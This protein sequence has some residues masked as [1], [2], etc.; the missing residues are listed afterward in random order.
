MAFLA[1]AIP[2][3]ASIAG[4]IIGGNAQKAAAST[5]ANSQL[6]LQNQ[7]YQQLLDAEKNYRTQINAIA[8]YLGAQSQAATDIRQHVPYLA[9]SSATASGGVF[10]GQQVQSTPQPGQQPQNQFQPPTQTM[11]NIGQAGGGANIGSVTIPGQGV[12]GQPGQLGA[13][14]S[15][16]PQQQAAQT[17]QGGMPR[18]LYAGQ[19]GNLGAALSGGR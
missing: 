7:E 6:D 18:F 2:A 9:P 17:Q 1:A 8:P 3:I 4:G 19:A 5:A 16:A 11:G 10:G 13:A 15:G 14:L 12:P